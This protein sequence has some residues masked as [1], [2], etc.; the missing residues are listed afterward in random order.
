MSMRRLTAVALL[1]PLAL[2]AAAPARAADRV[3]FAKNVLPLGR[4][5]DLGKTSPGTTMRI[6]I[7]L[8][9]PDAAGEAALAAAQ[10]NPASADY[11]RFLT[12]SQYNAR[13]GVSDAT[14]QRALAWLKG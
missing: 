8:R 2:V 11:S 3:E 9:H 13:F 14:F 1:A 4:A 5:T 6:G 7:G 10:S 12:P